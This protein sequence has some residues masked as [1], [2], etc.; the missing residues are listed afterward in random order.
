M[1]HEIPYEKAKTIEDKLDMWHLWLQIVMWCGVRN[2][3]LVQVRH[4]HT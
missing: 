4:K 2:R 1:I 3:W